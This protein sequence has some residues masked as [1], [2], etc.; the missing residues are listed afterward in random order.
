MT[1]GRKLAIGGLV[2]GGVTAYMA[3]VGASASWQYYLTADE[4]VADAEALRGDRIRV[5]GKVAA[6]SLTIAADRTQA[7]FLLE[8]TRERLRVICAGP[9]PDNLA[10][11]VEVVVEGRLEDSGLLRGSKVLTRCA[12]KYQS[13][14]SR[15][16]SHPAEPSRAEGDG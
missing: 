7:E 9:L 16:S 8:G 11:N 4:C 14:D 5:S 6:D 15:A 13:Q 1:T 2:V 12:S 10:E 3:Y